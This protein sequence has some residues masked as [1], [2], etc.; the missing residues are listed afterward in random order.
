MTENSN[1]TPPDDNGNKVI[2]G[3]YEITSNHRLGFEYQV[4][5]LLRFGC[6]CFDLEIGLLSRCD[7]ADGRYRVMQRYSALVTPLKPGD[8]F[9]LDQTYC[10]ITLASNALV[11]IEDVSQSEYKAHP[12]Y[13]A[14]S[15]ASYIGIPIK[16]D[17]DIYGTLSFSSA[18]PR[19]RKFS[20]MDID[21]LKLMSSWIGAELERHQREQELQTSYQQ[22]KLAE[23]MFRQAMEASPSAILMVDAKGKISYANEQTELLFGYEHLA[24]VD[25]PIEILIPLNA[26]ASHIQKRDDFMHTPSTRA[27]G[28]GRYLTACR[29]DGSEF[30]VEVALNPIQTRDGTIILCTLIDLSERQRFEAQIL[31]QSRA[32]QQANDKL[33]KQST[34]DELTGVGNRRELELKLETYLSLSRRNER[35]ISAIMLDLDD[36]KHFN[37]TYGHPQGDCAL[38]AL[39]TA[40]QETARRG[41]LVIRYGGEEFAIILPDT[42]REGALDLAQ[43][44]RSKIAAID[45][46]PIPM[47]ASLGVS[48]ITPLRDES[49]TPIKTRLFDEADKALYRAK[50]AGKNRACHFDDVC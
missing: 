28:Q 24:L 2:R 9:P 13:Q 18:T 47:T 21:A 38:V 43:R 25:Q 11:G 34:T 14:F 5:Q 35:E 32:L 6:E 26:R 41:D 30:P 8:E 42:G 40:L 1:A 46:L 50:R 3:L 22:I 37:D 49:I 29:R 48:T 19:I 39:A 17:G 27:M 20:A 31:A 7:G 4:Q 12:G 33:L 10:G 15:L 45:T 23:Q 16:V 36:F 44:L